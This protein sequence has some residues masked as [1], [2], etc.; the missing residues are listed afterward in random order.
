MRGRGVGGSGAWIPSKRATDIV[1]EPMILRKCRNL[2]S[3]SG[4]SLEKNFQ[5][6]NHFSH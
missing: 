2:R 6:K 3:S 1:F 4:L 5:E